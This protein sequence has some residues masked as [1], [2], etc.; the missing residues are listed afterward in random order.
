MDPVLSLNGPQVR[1]PPGKLPR[2][3]TP[4]TPFEGE[5]SITERTFESVSGELLCGTEKSVA[6]QER[7]R[8]SPF[9]VHFWSDLRGREL[10]EASVARW[11]L[12]RLGRSWRS[13]GNNQ[14]RFK[15]DWE[16]KDINFL[17]LCKEN[18]PDKHWK[19]L[20]LHDQTRLI[21]KALKAEHFLLDPHSSSMKYWDLVVVLALA[22]TGL[23][24][25][26]EVVF[27]KELNIG[28]F[29]T[30]RIF[31]TVFVLDMVLQLFL[32]VEV[33]QEGKYGTIVV[34]DP[35]V[36]RRRYFKNWFIVDL[37]SIL[38]FDVIML[39]LEE[40]SASLQR[41]KIFR[42]LRLLRLV[43]L[44]R[45]LR[46]SRIVLRW[47]NYLAIPFSQQKF[48]KFVV[49][50]ILVSHWMACLWGSVGLFLGKDLCPDP[51]AGPITAVEEVPVDE[52]SWITTHFTENKRSPDSPCN[53][54]HIYLAAL[55][56]SVMT[57]T[58]IGY[59]DISPVRDVEYVVCIGCMLAGGVLWAYII[60]C[61]CSILSNMHPVEENFETNT[62]LL[63]M[64]ME[65]V[66]MPTGQKQVYRE[67]LRE[68]KVHDAMTMFHQVTKSFSPLLRKELMLHIT[69]NWI[70]R[71]YYFKDAP[72]SL[73]M[74]LAERLFTRFFARREPLTD[75]RQCLCMIERGT[76]AHGG[77]I[78][79]P[80]N[81]FQED[82]IVSNPALQVVRPTVSLTY[83]L[84]LVLK[85]PDLD[86][87]LRSWP[88]FER[89]IRKSAA[90]LAMCRIVKLCAE[91]EQERQAVAAAAAVRVRHQSSLTDAFT[92]LDNC[93]MQGLTRHS[94]KMG[95]TSAFCHLD[96]KAYA[97]EPSRKSEQIETMRYIE[98]G[99]P[100]ASHFSLYGQEMPKRN[101][102]LLSEE[103][104]RGNARSSFFHQ[105]GLQSYSSEPASERRDSAEA[106]QVSTAPSSPHARRLSDTFQEHPAIEAERSAVQTRAEAKLEAERSAA[107]TRIEAKLDAM[108][109]ELQKLGQELRSSGGYSI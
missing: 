19:E 3:A 54:F 28:L 59:G 96:H 5:Q 35:K 10:E 16:P 37:V 1:L 70:R 46:T 15:S 26:Y 49:V 12:P 30:N 36:L 82:M 91:F 88:T 51:A 73:V 99:L 50:L 79:V 39:F 44:L 11:Q 90:K 18:Y 97:T 22:F 9:S 14:S 69:E 53:H 104:L 65:E 101:S 55:H 56:W 25:P 81:A 93:S 42:L 33:K 71:V 80:G 68:A 98:S 100:R 57:I 62:D 86:D 6:Q 31:D 94:T 17:D 105:P 95:I 108:A 102:S 66:A 78:L 13:R 45:I 43:K 52:V 74:E 75:I 83:T 40:P 23:I 32:K 106:P 21:A 27:T 89:Q 7:R 87:V 8:D 109:L 24:T 67:Y 4:S 76:L 60:G 2:V 34:R 72:T 29:I 64:I 107:Q 77:M 84:I 63:N 58:S 47:Q 61:T 38:P 103:S 85:R 48:L 92:G 41:M 20:P